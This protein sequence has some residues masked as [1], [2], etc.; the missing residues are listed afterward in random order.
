[1]K[2]LEFI[3]PSNIGGAE[4]YVVN[5]S[6]KFIGKGH[7]VFILSSHALTEKNQDLHFLP[8]SGVPFKI[9]NADFK[10]SP[11]TVLRVASFLKKNGFDIIH[12]HLS[13]ANFI[14]ALAAR[15]AGIKSVSTAHGLNKKSQYKYADYVICVSGAVRENLISQGMKEEKLGIIY[16]GIDI[17]KFNP[18]AESLQGRKE[19]SSDLAKSFNAGIIA[20]LSREKGVDLFL[21]AAKLVLVKI[22]DAK[23]FIAG[24]GALKEALVKKASDL[25]I[26]D[27]VYFLGFVGGAGLVSFLNELDAVVFPSLKEGLPLSLLESMAMKKIVIASDAGGMPEVVEDGK[28]GFIVKKGDINSIY[29]KL[30][31]VYNNSNT[32]KNVRD[33]AR[34]TVAEK[35]NIEKCADKTL[36]LF[37]KYV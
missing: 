25:G 30:I 3:T 9:I 12:T 27:S 14:G 15:I 6:K 20:R 1:M 29:Q 10:Y 13:K 26:S 7:E 2:I 37:S 19:D 35:F 34:K 11:F 5:I 4:N 16:N 28:N 23:F 33:E 36:E 22:P 8:E 18:D 24:A 31:F 21:E 32:L 17:N